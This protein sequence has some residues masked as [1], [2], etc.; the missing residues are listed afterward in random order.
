MKLMSDIGNK[1]WLGLFVWLLLLLSGSCIRTEVEEGDIP[2]HAL[3]E[4][5]AG[6]HLNVVANR[7]PLTRSIT[8]TADGSV[9]SDTLTADGKGLPDTRAANPL[10]NEQESL[11][12][13]IWVGQYAVSDGTLLYNKYISS[14]TDNTVNIK[15]KRNRNEEKCRVWFVANV[16]D[17]G[18]IATET[19]VKEH[20]LSYASTET[21]LPVNNLC[22][23]TGQWE[24]VV[25]EGGIRDIEVKLTRLV[26]K[27][28]FT[29]SMVGEEFTFTPTTVTLCS[30]PQKMQI[31]VPKSQQAGMTYTNYTG[32]AKKTGATMYWYLPENMA[33]TVN[34]SD[35][36]DSEKK[37]TGK[38]VS[39][40]TYIELTG[41]AEQGGVTY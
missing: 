34:G 24:G 38:G 36:V 32:I 22:G 8:F 12:A 17:L 40:A 20:L 16:G 11:V 37:K 26:A 23:M 10:N 29:Y 6:F 25:Q 21:G 30:V 5:D 15:L 13:G 3:K 1:R 14:L 31:D 41:T 7:T 18:K 39:N 4:V 2:L 9:E 19:E 28:S 27:I 35:A 33:G